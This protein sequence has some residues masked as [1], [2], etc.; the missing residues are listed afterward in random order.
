MNPTLLAAKCP[1]KDLQGILRRLVAGVARD[2]ERLPDRA[3]DRVHEI[4]VRM[5]KFRA[6]LRLAEPA[7]GRQEFLKSDKLA[8]RLK[9]DFGSAR[10]DDVLA[11]LLLD[12]LGRDEAVEVA[13]TLG[14]RCRN[15]GRMPDLSAARETCSALASRVGGCRI[16]GLSA[17]E[18]FGAW[19]DTYRD[20]RRAMRACCKE[21]A[22]DAGFHEW[23]KRVKELLYQS[24]AIGPPPAK[25]ALKAD[26]LASVLGSQHDLSVLTVRLAASSPGSRAGRAAA[27]KKKRVARQA[28]AMGRKLFAK[29]PSAM[30]GKG[31]LP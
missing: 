19:L 10:D 18:I 25:L 9:D 24:A 26:R 5:K 11:G 22:D 4:R 30:R 17:S 28:L 23:R 20:S 1:G 7:L 21:A 27:A 3:E 8:R 15:D 2:I 13:S 14:L 12:L 29:K 16:E 6:V 31:A